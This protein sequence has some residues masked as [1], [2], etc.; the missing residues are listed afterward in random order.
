MATAPVRDQAVDSADRSSIVEALDELPP[1]GWQTTE[2]QHVSA[3][4]RQRLLGL[5]EAVRR[6]RSLTGLSLADLVGE[7]ER[8]LGLDIEVLARP[9]HTPATARAHLDA[10]ADVAATF[11]VSA[12]RPTL[13]GFLSWLDAAQSEERGLDKGTI[14]VST[15]AVQVLTVHAAKGLE[16]DVVAVPGLVEGS[17]PA[18]SGAGTSY[19]DGQWRMSPPTDKGWCGGLSGVPY[20]LRG[21]RDGLPVLGWRHAPDLKALEDETSRFVSDGG[22]HGIEEERRLAYVAFTRARSALM[23]TAP[24]WAD[25]STP[26][27]TS[28]FL[29]ELLDHD[30]LDLVAAA[31]RRAARARRPRQGGQPPPGRTGLG[32]VAGRPPRRPPCRPQRGGGDGRWRG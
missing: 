3:V 18:R 2:G 8:A 6:L 14:E 27:L 22:E 24:V 28:R 21:D 29:T 25:A 15:D 4:A 10:F 17:F 23:L 32:A 5:R 12:D 16:W 7:A 20:D 11:A 9:E 13:G 19:K 1:P 31:V 30:Q 26:R